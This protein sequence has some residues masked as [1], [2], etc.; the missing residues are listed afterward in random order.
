MSNST[1]ISTSELRKLK[2]KALTRIDR[3]QKVLHSGQYGVPRLV[4]NIALDFMEKYPTMSWG[5]ALF[6]AQAYC[7]RT[8]G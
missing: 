6:A 1:E 8:H 3:E 7:D 2:G 4:M 5:D